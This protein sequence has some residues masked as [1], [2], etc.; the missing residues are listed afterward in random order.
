MALLQ[1]LGTGQGYLK[2]GILGFPKA[3][4]TFTA[5]ELAIGT[6][7]HLGEQGPIAM[8][9]TEGG[10]EYIHKRVREA[11][12]IDLMG[13][14]SRS[15]DDLLAVGEECVTEGVSVLVVDSVTHIW[16]ELCDAYLK[17]VNDGLRARKFRTRQKLEFQDWNGVKSLWGKWTD[18]YLNS[19]VHIV[20]CGR[21]GFEYDMETNQETGRKELIKTGTKMKVES[22]FGFEPSLLIEMEREKNMDGLLVHRATIIGDRFNIIDGAQC[23]NPT[24]DFFRPH[25][26]MLIPGA[27]APIDTAIKSDIPMDE[28]GDVDYQQE[29]KKRAICCEEIQGLLV[30]AFPGQS[31]DEKKAKADALEA[32]F[33]SRSWTRIESTPSYQLELGV[34]RMKEYLAG[35]N[36][37]NSISQ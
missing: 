31:A 35:L 19:K 16:R 4:K 17:K 12:G 8:F 30:S 6:R 2:A 32:V 23:D 14:R 37:E 34:G 18:F 25:I 24:F 21:A 22:E 33:A 29:R 27:H 1:K 3:G 5:I 26:D 9:D 20:I 15:F 13:I 36:Q 7:N 11:T 28:E 10:S